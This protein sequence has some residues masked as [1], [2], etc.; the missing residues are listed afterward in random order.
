MTLF[1]DVL[2]PVPIPGTFTYRVPQEYNEALQVGQRVVVQFGAKKLY[3]ALVR[4]IHDEVPKNTFSVKYLLS[5]IDPEPIADEQ[6]FR[7]WEWMAQ[8]YMCTPG[9]VMAM[10]LPSALKLASESEITIHPEFDGELSSLAMHELQVVQILSEHPVMKVADISKALGL[11]K[12][13]PLLNNMI[14]RR[15]I[16]MDEDIKERFKPK[17]TTYLHINPIYR[18]EEA[19]RALFDSLEGSS[20]TQKQL[21]VMLKF[22][23]LSRMGADALPKKQLADCKELSD[24]ALNTLIKNGVLVCEERE[25]SRLEHYDTTTDPSQIVLNEEQQAAYDY[26]SDPDSPAIS[27]LHGVTSSGKTEVYIKLIENTLKEGRQVLFLL[28]EIALTAQ[29]INRL[30]R[31]FGDKVGVYH[32]KFSPG[33]RAEVWMRTRHRDPERRYSILLGARSALFLPFQN[34]GLV[35]VDEEHDTSY[36]QNEPAPRYSGRDSALYLARMHGARTVLG[37][38]TPS[39]ETYFSAKQKRYGYCQMTHR[40]GGLQM[41]EVLCVDMKEA[42]RR[43]EVKNHFSD[44]LLQHIH[45]ALDNHEQVILYQN[46]RGFSLHIECEKCG[47]IPQCRNC[48]VSLVYHKDTNTLR[49]HYCGYSIPVPQ[50]CPECHSHQLS[51][52]GFGTE[53]VEDDLRILFP[54]AHVGRLDID[55]ATSRNKYLDIINDFQDHKIDI[56]VGTQMVTKGLDF[57]NVSVV[58]I[59]SADSIIIFPDF[60]SYERAFQQMT[61]VSGRAGRHGHQGKVIIQTFNPWHQAIRDVIDHDYIR[62]YDGQ[63]ADRRV[64][65]YPPYY[66]L[67]HITLRHRDEQVLSDAAARLAALMRGTFG[68]RVVGPGFP[69]VKRVRGLFIK[70]IMIRFERGEAIA[71]SK[72]ILRQMAESVSNDHQYRPI[73]IHFDVDPQ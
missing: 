36:K 51:M 17:T 49:C 64:F 20:R 18:D 37:S 42:H 11:Q 69:N 57:D 5:I 67:I 13:M 25:S 6:M 70:N 35:I 39:I 26:L 4:R 59:L 27:L 21:A 63:I 1:A 44:F 54:D 24:S 71:E 2:L 56:L 31:Y 14:E 45:A 15:I 34:L 52:K 53:R 33:Q 22:M 60:R 28:P 73:M 9:E 29:I 65:C 32:S 38:A 40:Y 58:G 8:Y 43:K 12:I 7:F 41:P 30:R 46:R 16:V 66:R 10:A 62:M 50:E 19:A 61:Q 48:D 23:Q 3:S 47:W 68:N 55:S 72:E